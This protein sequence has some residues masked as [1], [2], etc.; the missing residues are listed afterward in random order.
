VYEDGTPYTLWVYKEHPAADEYDAALL[1]AF[2]LA[3][4]VS[5]RVVTVRTVAGEDR[6]TF[7]KL[8]RASDQAPATVTH[9]EVCQRIWHDVVFVIRDVGGAVMATWRQTSQWRRGYLW[10]L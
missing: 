9:A 5:P 4:A 10:V 2:G 3:S 8:Q 7:A 6:T 1:T